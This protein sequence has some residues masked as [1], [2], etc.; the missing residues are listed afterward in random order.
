MMGKFW[1]GFKDNHSN[2]TMSVFRLPKTLC[3]EINSMMGKFWWDFKDNHSK[4]HWMS[5]SGLGRKKSVGGL[6]YRNLESFNTALLAK[7][8]WRLTKFPTTLAVRVF[9]E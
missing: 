4:I 9:K 6:G 3:R 2:Y 8:C 7:Q 1:W 5:W